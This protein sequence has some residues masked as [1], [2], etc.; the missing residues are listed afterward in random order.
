M[1]TEAPTP[2]PNRIP[3]NIADEMRQSYMDY[4]M[5]VIIGRALP[6]VRDGLKPANR[7]VLYGMQQMG[8]QPGRP[9]RKSAKI[10]GEVMGNYHPHGDQ[11]IYDTQVRMAQPFNMR[12]TLVDGQGNFGSIDGDPPAAQRYTEARLTRLGASMMEDIERDTVDYQPTYDDSST[13]PSVLPTVHP[14]LLV[15]GSAGIAVGMATNIPPHNLVE[16]VDGLTFLLQN[17]DLTPDER[18]EGLLQRIPGP[19]F[20]T[21][22]F[23]LGREGICQAYRTGRGTVIMRARAEIELRKNDRESI[24]VTEIPY[25]VNKSRLIEKIADLARKDRVR[26]IADVRDESGRQGMRI[27]VDVKRGE[28]ARVVLNNLYKHTQLQDSFGVI[29]LA[30]VEQRPRV[31][32]L[33]DA[34]ELFLDFRRDVVSRRAAFELRKAQARA[35]V[36]EGYV[37]AL[38]HLDAVITLIRG[39]RTPQDARVGL[40]SRFELT[41]IQ[42]DEILKLQLQ[43]LTGLEREKIVEELAALLERIADLKDILAS[44]DRIDH[45]VT[46][47][48][49]EMR[50]THGDERRTEIVAA[51]NEIAIEDLIADEDVAISITHTGYVKRT[52]LTNYRAQ[53]RGGR[54]RV[55]M[56]TRDEDFVSDLFIASTHSY[57]LIF[58]DRGRIYWLKV[59]AIPDVTRQAK[60]KPVV[61]L[62]SLQS[63][64][65]IAAF[66]SVRDFSSGN[67]VLLATRRGIVKKTRLVAF[68][69]PRPSG[70]IALSI[71]EGD[72]LIG[73]VV[74]S[75]EDNLLI[76]TERGMTIHFRETDAR[77]LGRSAYGVKGINLADGD[78]AVSLEV[79]RPGGSILTV[80]RD[81]FGKRTPVEDYRLQTRGGKG[82]INIKTSGRNGP[83]VGL[84]FLA[85]E[86]Q[87]ML[88]TEKG[89]IIRL[90]TADISIIGRNTQGVRLIQLE[91]GDRV[92][93]VA[94]LA[95]REDDEESPG[96]PPPTGE[97]PGASKEEQ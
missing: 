32:S 26:G 14:N 19:D 9:Y 36:L 22:G 90:N 21:G 88:I 60:G 97:P 24:V 96:S 18:L 59:H 2:P 29:F 23:I 25:Q 34:S 54:G 15:N 82:L 92:V 76:G 27:V 8:L 68:S 58:T 57:I 73:A 20:P 87:V 11:A 33:L 56:R 55:G 65:K 61:N 6:D 40:V 28:P 74:T 86:E 1:E 31:L 75:G 47:E 43:R 71:E 83:V 77:P 12:A 93:S 67:H 10:V 48:L 45:I 63:G 41:E 7:R 49:H 64:E 52:S 16:V 38:D 17:P 50:D 70:I 72:T 81:G 13:E 95:E 30:I 89:M 78:A 37:I 46:E 80:T 3:T 51:T 44:P 94:R 42:A 91:Q 39:S 62:V 85:R 79:V 5:S 35:H 66:C 84:R 53:K 4:A 69:K